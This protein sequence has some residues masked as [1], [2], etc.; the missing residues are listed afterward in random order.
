MTGAGRLN[1]RL[2]PEMQKKLK[3]LERRTGLSTSE[4]VRVSIEHYYESLREN[5]GGRRA[6]ELLANFVGASAGPGDVSS[7]YKEHLADALAAKYPR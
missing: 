2:D 4:V 6:R 7:R 3:Y 5:N 1:A